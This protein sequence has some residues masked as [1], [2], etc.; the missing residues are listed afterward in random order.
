VKA[1]EVKLRIWLPRALFLVVE[2]FD[3]SVN[4]VYSKFTFSFFFPPRQKGLKGNKYR[5][6]LI[7]P[8]FLDT[9]LI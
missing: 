8:A 2:M 9:M 3:Q 4:V 7:M 5:V 1:H 6:M